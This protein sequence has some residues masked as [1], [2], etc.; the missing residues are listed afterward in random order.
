MSVPVFLRDIHHRLIPLFSGADVSRTDISIELD[1]VLRSINCQDCKAI[2]IAETDGIIAAWNNLQVCGPLSF[3]TIC[4]AP[5]N[6]S[7]LDHNLMLFLSIVTINDAIQ[8]TR[9]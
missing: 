1:L 9:S 6:T 7:V 4:A 5:A 8:R 3:D 2:L